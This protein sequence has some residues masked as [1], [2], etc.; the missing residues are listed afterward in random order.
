M[1]RPEITTTEDGSPTLRHP[2][3][4]DTYHSLRGAVGEALHVFI[5]EGFSFVALPRTRILEIGFGSGLNALLTAKAAAEQRRSVDYTAIERYPIETDVAARLDYAAEPL[6]MPMHEAPW[7]ESVPIAPHFRLRKIEASLPGYR[8]DGT[9]DL[10]YFDAFAPDTQPE[11]WSRE[12]FAH[13]YD[14][15]SPGGILVTYSAKGSVKENLRAAGFEVRRL[16]GALGKR[17]MVRAVKPSFRT[18]D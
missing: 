9:F 13:L 16:P 14:R 15:L 8:F 12:I 11:M 3:T 6:F 18:D 5:R 7:G 2:L 17:H 4:G 1:V 10:I